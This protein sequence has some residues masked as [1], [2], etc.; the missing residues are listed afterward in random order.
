MIK[1]KFSSE[2]SGQLAS[3]YRAV[4]FNSTYAEIAAVDAG[5]PIVLGFNADVT[6]SGLTIKAGTVFTMCT[7]TSVADLFCFTGIIH[8]HSTDV[9]Y[10]LD[11]SVD[12]N[13]AWALTLKSI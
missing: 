13:N 12:S 3:V 10:A 11:A 1:K 4:A 9:W 8:S 6:V 5:V 7:D 2:M